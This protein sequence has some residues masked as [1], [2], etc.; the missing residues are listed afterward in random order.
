MRKAAIA[1]SA[2]LG[3]VAAVANAEADGRYQLVTRQGVAE[4]TLFMLDT[5][6]GDTWELTWVKV[7]TPDGKPGTVERW[8][9]IEKGNAPLPPQPLPATVAGA[10]QP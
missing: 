8:L 3:L 1:L 6:T 5:V 7:P 2:A 9:P 10:S 4:Q